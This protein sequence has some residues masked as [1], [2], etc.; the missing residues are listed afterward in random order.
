M[1]VLRLMNSTLK[2]IKTPQHCLPVPSQDLDF[3]RYMSSSSFCSV[4]MRGALL[5]L[6]E[7]V[8]ITG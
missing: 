4:K 6:V 3:Q 5:I 2:Y 7:L 8:A 1:Y